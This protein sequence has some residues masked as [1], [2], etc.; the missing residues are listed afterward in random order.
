MTDVVNELGK[1]KYKTTYII[2]DKDTKKVLGKTQEN[3]AKAKEIAKDLY[4]KNGYRGKAICTYT[5]E[6]V[7]GQTKAFEIEY[8]ASKSAK[9][10]YFIF[11]GIERN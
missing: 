6:V 5:K 9:E 4:V 10:G 1:R 11:F 8:Q 2:T 3:K 7:E